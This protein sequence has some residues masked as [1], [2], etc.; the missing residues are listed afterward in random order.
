MTKLTLVDLLSLESDIGTKA[1][2]S[3]T[4]EF[5]IKTIK[6]EVAKGNTVDLSGL[7]SFVPALQK[8]KSGKVPGTDTEYSTEDKMVPKFRAGKQFKDAVAAGK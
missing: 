3:R 8:G 2:A 6:D 5:I 7:G 1:A 4:V